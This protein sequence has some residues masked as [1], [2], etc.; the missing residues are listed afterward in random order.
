MPL[1]KD[2]EKILA[3]P[4]LTSLNLANGG[5]FSADMEQLVPLLNQHPQITGLNISIN[6]IGDKGGIALCGLKYIHHLNLNRNNIRYSIVNLILNPIFKSIDL[7]SND[8]DDS[9]ALSVVGVISR[10][11]G[12]N[13]D[14]NLIEPSTLEAIQAKLGSYLFSQQKQSPESP[15]PLSPAQ[16][17]P[18]AMSSLVSARQE[19]STKAKALPP[20]SD[21]TSVREQAGKEV[22]QTIQ[23]ANPG[24]WEKVRSDP[25]I[26][27]IAKN[28]AHDLTSSSLRSSSS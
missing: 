14:L 20:K 6:N 17:V 18:S 7:S 23:T 19:L 3:T 27:E 21:Q 26:F 2:I 1:P 10:P 12:L 11:L 4:H 13:L 25:A 5:L 16:I 24:L 15:P 8:I 22:L 28:I 9:V